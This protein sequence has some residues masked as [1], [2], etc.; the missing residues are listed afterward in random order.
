MALN[1][2]RK[3][4]SCGNFSFE[5]RFIANHFKTTNIIQPLHLR[6]EETKS[7]KSW[8]IC[9]KSIRSTLVT[10]GDPGHRNHYNLGLFFP[11]QKWFT[12]HFV[13]TYFNLIISS[14]KNRRFF[15]NVS[16]SRWGVLLICNSL[17]I[18]DLQP[19]LNLSHH[20]NCQALPSMLCIVN[21]QALT[22]VCP[23][24]HLL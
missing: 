3:K 6:D 22:V 2:F 1:C 11:C 20:Q 23:S 14:L 7:Q 13:N 9:L 24:A 5:N 18:P 4:S 16:R 17:L 15:S 21:I 19:T 8:V 10:K 12:L